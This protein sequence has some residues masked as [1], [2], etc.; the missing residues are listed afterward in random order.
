MNDV[1]LQTDPEN[2]QA[3]AP[4]AKVPLDVGTIFDASNIDT[5]PILLKEKNGRIIY[6]YGL[7][8]I[9]VVK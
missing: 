6:L 8:I 7:Q 5:E 1:I 9:V 2:M 4:T 3:S